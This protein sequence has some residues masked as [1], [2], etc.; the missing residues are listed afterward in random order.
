M[1]HYENDLPVQIERSLRECGCAVDYL[2]QDCRPDH[3]ARLFVPDR[4]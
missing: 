2:T 4:R 3:A 1:V